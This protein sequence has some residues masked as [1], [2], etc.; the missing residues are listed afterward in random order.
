MTSIL[1]Q[2]HRDL[3]CL[4]VN[5]GDDPAPLRAALDSVDDGRL[6]VVDLPHNRGRYFVDAVTAQACLTE[7]W[8][9]HDADDA[10]EPH[11]LETLLAAAA[12]A[13]AAFSPFTNHREDGTRQHRPIRGRTPD[14][15]L[16]YTTHLSQLWRTETARAL[17][18]PGYRVAYDAV[19]TTTALYYGRV[20]L[21]GDPSYH[22]IRRPDSL[23]DSAETGRGSPHR[24]ETRRRLKSLWRAIDA[25]SASLDDAA[26]II[27]SD[28]SP[29]LAAEVGEQAARLRETLE[30]R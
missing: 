3:T 16:R 1:A 5:D 22:R 13:D 9:P 19:M 8:V 10:S 6:A 12:S 2:T 29:G 11:R 20:A 28:I 25:G 18:H 15:R 14:R 26:R 30:A 27:R 17:A 7:W 4:V 21:H 24:R 23:V